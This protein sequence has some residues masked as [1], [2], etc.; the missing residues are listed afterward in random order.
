MPTVGAAWGAPHSVVGLDAEPLF[1][2]GSTIGVFLARLAIGIVLTEATPSHSALVVVSQQGIA[3]EPGAAPARAL[4]ATDAFVDAVVAQA[5]S[6]FAI[7]A[8]KT[9]LSGQ[10][11]HYGRVIGVAGSGR[12]V[13]I[14]C[15][16][17]QVAVCA[18][19]ESG[20]C[21]CLSDLPGPGRYIV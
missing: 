6:T 9:V 19:V 18:A 4:L 10:E 8:R 16:V 3:I 13:S 14:R 11:R 21:V 7:D 12:Y 15:A 2:V 1:A 17:G 20:A 5:D